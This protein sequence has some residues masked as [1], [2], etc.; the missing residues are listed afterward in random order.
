MKAP[1]NSQLKSAAPYVIGVGLL[2]LLTRNKGGL[3]PDNLPP[4]VIT[5][6]PTLTRPAARVIAD[7]IFGA[8]YGSG[9]FW[10]G[11]T[12]ENEAAVIAALAF[13]MN[14]ADVLLVID[15]YGSRS[16]TWSLSGDLDLPA[17]ITRYLSA[18]NIQDINE[19]FARR[20]IQLRF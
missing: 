20:G 12:T 4:P 10:A 14:D 19:G 9:G 16:G 15:E 13:C 6:A 7:T 17:T 2:Y 18:A 3:L 8:I 11:Q 1:S 5:T